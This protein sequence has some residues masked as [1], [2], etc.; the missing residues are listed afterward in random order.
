MT[1]PPSPR[2]FRSI[3]TCAFGAPV[4]RSAGCGLD[5][6]PGPSLAHA[7]AARA[8]SPLGDF[9]RR[10]PKPI[11]ESPS[12]RVPASLFLGLLLAASVTQAV[13]FPVLK[14]PAEMFRR[15]RERFLEKLVPNSI[16]ILH[17]APERTMSNDVEYVYRQDSDFYYLTGLEE[18]GAIAVLRPGAADGKRYILFVQPHDA[19]AEAFQGSRLGPDGAVSQYGAD[20][21]FPIADLENMLFRPD[22][23]RVPSGYLVGPEALYLADGGD[24][25]WGERLRATINRLRS[26]DVSPIMIDPRQILH[27][28]RL[29]KD[30]DE[31]ALLRRAAD[32][33]V[34]AHTLAMR[35]A[36]PG[37][38]E[39]E[40]QAALDS[41]CMAN[42]ARRM[43][44]P[45]IVGAGPD[46]I[47]LH[48]H[49]NDRQMKDGEVLLNDSGAEYGYYATD[50]TRTY[51][52]SGHF[53]REQRAVYEAVLAAQKG[54]MA[55]VKPGVT[56][57]EVEKTSARL[58]TEG[59]VK[60]GL[61]TGDVDKL[62]A[63]ASY[64]RFTVHGIS[65]WVG[66][67]VHDAG[68]Y[69]I[70]GQSRK[71]EA[72]MVLTVEP[73]I[74]I[75]ANMPGVDPRWWNIG[76]RIED[77]VL[78]TPTGFDCLSCGAP[79]E[80]EDVEKAVQAGKK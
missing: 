50:I 71:L 39:Y 78:V 72:G 80:A 57:D 38:Y 24:T 46:S 10:E 25:E 3:G 74:Y 42:G 58:Q 49:K 8:S 44:Y 28:L 69:S 6:P 79:K 67:D 47:F 7:P 45:S 35:A 60:L 61:L 53:S 2:R 63:D 51:P 34:R 13:D 41:Y 22:S 19:R 68:R 18:P 30:S 76:V 32:M 64:R 77:T 43:A 54:T 1:L 14:P 16:V 20:A 23:P 9:A 21:A 40:I 29:V 65:H 66:L 73:G 75:P 12:P 52:V 4:A 59:L 5:G 27:E 55:T 31:L 56:H 15:H 70:A 48:W 26:R 33:S 17:A 36:A 62:V 11:P 37:K